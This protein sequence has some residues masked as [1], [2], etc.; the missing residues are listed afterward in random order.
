[1]YYKILILLVIWY[2]FI[3]GTLRF[4][5]RRENPQKRILLFVHILFIMGGLCSKPPVDY[6]SESYYAPTSW[7]FFEEKFVA[8]GAETDAV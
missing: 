3:F 4:G 6:T 2:S 1:L 5:T 8:F 7:D